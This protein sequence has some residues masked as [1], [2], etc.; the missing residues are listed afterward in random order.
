MQ[1]KIISIVLTILSL[2]VFAAEE[3]IID[4]RHVKPT[5]ETQ[6]VERKMFMEKLRYQRTGGM[7]EKSGSQNGEI[8]YVNCQKSADEAWLKESIEYLKLYSKFNISMTNGE[9]NFPNPNIYGNVSL[10]IV[11]NPTLPSLLVAPENRWAMV[12]VVPLQK[13]TTQAYFKAR[14]KK[15]LSRAFAALCG[16]CNSKYPDAL[17]GAITKPEDLDKHADDRLTVDVFSR[18]ESYMIPFGVTPAVIRTYWQAC[19]EGWAP[20]PTNDV[21]KAIWDKVHSAPKAPMK[22]EFDPKKGR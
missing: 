16:F 15:E 7:V 10:Y 11:E 3:L 4:W 5:N 17:T 14:V 2:S 22:I 9:F 20:A 13:N 8:V 1:Y 6:R 18:F 19:N 21:Q 12:N